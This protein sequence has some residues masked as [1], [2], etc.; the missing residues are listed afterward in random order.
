[1]N[2]ED[3]FWSKTKVS[4]SGCIEWIAARG[5]NTN[6]TIGYGQFHMGERG[7]KKRRMY[8]AHRIAWELTNGPIPDGMK[9]LHKCDNQA[10]VRPDHL[11]IGTQY[12]N[13]AD[14][15]SK[16]RKRAAYGQAQGSSILREDQVTE[17]RKSYKKHSRYPD[18]GSSIA[19]ADKFGCSRGTITDIVT[20]A[21]RHIK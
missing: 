2:L 14:M 7:S 3:R 5:K 12:D 16:G 6:G 1:M 21:W 8:S 18:P 20:R 10:C 15:I 13:V 9:V 11:F 19:L 17:I 4:N